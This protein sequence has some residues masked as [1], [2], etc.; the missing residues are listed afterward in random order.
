M[1]LSI[2]LFLFLVVNPNTWGSIYI[3]VG[4]SIPRDTY[5]GI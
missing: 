5:L 2:E 3:V 1:E 4:T